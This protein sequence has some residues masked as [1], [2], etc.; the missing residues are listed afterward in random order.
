M[1]V[2]V[3]VVIVVVDIVV[4]VASDIVAVV[5]NDNVVVANVLVFPCC[6]C[7][8]CSYCWRSC[9]CCVF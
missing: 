7:H 3:V 6:F 2:I 5:A 4:V 8:H 1:V 9:S